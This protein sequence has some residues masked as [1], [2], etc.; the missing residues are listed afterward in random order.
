MKV[1]DD[2][3][4]TIFIC[5]IVKLKVLGIKS[6]L[7]LKIENDKNNFTYFYNNMY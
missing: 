3:Q 7:F 1:R 4:V 6:P 5:I 2:I